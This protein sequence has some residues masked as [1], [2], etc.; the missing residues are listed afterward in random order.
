MA[1][2]LNRLHMKQVCQL[3]RNAEKYV[4]TRLQLEYLQEYIDNKKNSQGQ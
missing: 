4:R 2:H 1:N 3:K